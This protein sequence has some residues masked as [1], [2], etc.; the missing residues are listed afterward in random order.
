MAIRLWPPLSAL[1]T[2]SVESQLL[3]VLR[4][5]ADKSSS[6]DLLVIKGVKHGLDVMVYGD[7]DV[8]RIGS[9]GLLD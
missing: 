5:A 7:L 4:L 8:F 3:L 9:V 1:T 6:N 2:D